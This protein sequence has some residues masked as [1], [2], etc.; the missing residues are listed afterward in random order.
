MSRVIM[1]ALAG[2]LSLLGSSAMAETQIE[3]GK[4][5]AE[6]M[7]CGDCHTPGA[8]LGKPDTSN[9]LGG[10]EVGY[11]IPMLGIFYGANLTPDQ[12]TGLGTWSEAEIITALRTGVRPDGRILAA[13]MPWRSFAALTDKD[14]Q[15]IAAYLKSLKPF[16]RKVPGPFGPSEKATSYYYG[17]VIPA[18]K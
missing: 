1:I 7:A 17:F 15:A 6:I 9:P 14:A 5:L 18:K 10:S 11:E 13:A 16:A 3:R 2:L 12:D 4:Y 8:L